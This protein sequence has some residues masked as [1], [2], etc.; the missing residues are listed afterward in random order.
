MWLWLQWDGLLRFLD[1][2][3]I[4]IDSNTVE[5][6]MR[7]VPLNRKNALFAGSGEG[8]KNW[9][10]LAPLVKTCKLHGINPEAYFADILT[11]LINNWPN[12]RLGKLLPCI[13]TPEAS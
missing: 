1:D 6:A 5:R 9:A 13:W 11:K 7:P 4:K 2:G 3:R 12:R 10:M 8:A